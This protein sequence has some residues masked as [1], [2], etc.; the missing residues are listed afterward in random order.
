MANTDTICA[1]ATPQGNASVSI[2]RLSGPEALNIARQ[3]TQ[4][5]L[6]PRCAHFSTLLDYNG[7]TA[8][9]QAVVIYFPQPNSLTGEDVVEFQCHGNP[10]V[11]KSLLQELCRHGA[12]LAIAGEFS[13]R[14]FLNGKL[15]LSQL[16][17]IADLISSGSEQA[18][19]SAVLSMQG[20]FS[21][22]VQKILQQ[23]I[24]IR[25]YI[26]AS[27]DFSEE[28]IDSAVK[29]DMQA[30][31]EST[32]KEI[33]T[34]F[35]IAQKGVQMQRGV[36]V[37]LTGLPNVGK[38]SLLNALSTEERAIV[39]EIPGTTRDVVYVDME[40]NGIPIRLIDTAGLRTDA[41]IVE[42]EGIERAR[43][44]IE[45]ADL[46]IHVIDCSQPNAATEELTHVSNRLDVYNKADLL[47]DNVAMPSNAILVSAKTGAG[48]SQLRENIA[49]H[50]QLQPQDA[51]TPFSARTR[52]LDAMR[53]A[54]ASIQHALQQLRIDAPMELA[55]EDLRIA[56]QCLGEITG[57]FTPDDLLDYIFR[58]F[59]IG[60]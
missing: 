12:R 45:N 4:I 23:I 5:E 48:I 43:M 42:Q 27:L 59:C 40:I 29:P 36:S 28:D 41:G 26:E 33:E 44:A 16:E 9:D 2:V 39:T 30:K 13:E 37:V 6:V 11:V 31:L 21:D 55:A 49:T 3:L 60:K 19:R 7:K 47:N 22:Q 8:I 35:T 15:D 38:S 14:A 58:E 32:R 52:H 46:V 51:Q 57:E 17:A 18:A 50:L 25:T 53:R 54:L 1:Q 56:Q 20:K 34:I 10:F 24:Q